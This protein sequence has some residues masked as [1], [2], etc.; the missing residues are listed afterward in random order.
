MVTLNIEFFP[1][2][3][4][5]CAT[6]QARL[7][8]RKAGCGLGRGVWARISDSGRA[9]LPPC[10]LHA[11]HVAASRIP[12]SAVVASTRDAGRRIRVTGSAIRE[13]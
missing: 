11:A 13:L 1:L 3:S 12:V 9:Q 4:V 10:R 7:Y 8:V 2:G 5:G 6:I